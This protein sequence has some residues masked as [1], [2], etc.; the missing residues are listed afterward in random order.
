MSIKV[1]QKSFMKKVVIFMFVLEKYVIKKLKELMYLIIILKVKKLNFI[2][3]IME[4]SSIGMIRLMKK[5]IN[6]LHQ[7]LIFM[8]IMMGI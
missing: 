3:M 6:L 4:K 1:K 5:C 7:Q 8:K 2:L